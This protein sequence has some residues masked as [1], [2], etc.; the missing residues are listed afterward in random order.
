MTEQVIKALRQ[1]LRTDASL[2]ALLPDTS[3]TS[4]LKT[5]CLTQIKSFS[6]PKS[7]VS[8]HHKNSVKPDSLFACSFPLLV[9][10]Q[11]SHGTVTEDE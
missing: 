8:S 4:N 7:Y 6:L 9:P 1:E 10:A 2:L 3:F 11:V 5:G